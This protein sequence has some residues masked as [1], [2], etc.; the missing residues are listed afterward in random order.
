MSQNFKLQKDNGIL[1]KS[2]WGAD[3]NDKALLELAKILKNIA[4]D[5]INSRYKKDI[6]DLLWKYRDE[7][8][9]NV[10]MN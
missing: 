9:K 8:L 2:F 1:I 6:R 5:M 7:I 10:S 4:I 3:N